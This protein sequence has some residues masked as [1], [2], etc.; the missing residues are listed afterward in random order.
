LGL[1]LR[2]KI[3]KRYTWIT[4]LCGADK[5][6]LR[7]L[8]QK[9]LGG[10]E[11]WC[12]RRKEKLRGTE[13]VRTEQVSYTAKEGRYILNTAKRRKATC[14]GHILRR[15][16]LL[17]HVTERKLQR[18][19]EM[20]GRWGRRRKQLLNDLKGKRRYWKLKEEALDRTLWRTRF[21]RGYGPD[22]RQTAQRI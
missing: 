14:F 13:R 21:G 1:N 2:K 20:I 3:I 7:K 16:C 6:A 5:W 4:A 19:I 22:V 11:K 12:W 17:K 10:S 18:K 8:Q 15:N 9:H